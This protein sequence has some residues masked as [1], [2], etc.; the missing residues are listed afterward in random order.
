MSDPAPFALSTVVHLVRPWGEPVTDL[1]ELRAALA[2]A[3]AEV[4]FQHTV[5]V[6][7]RNPAA[8]E[9][10]ADDLS[11]WVAVAAQ[12][13]ETAERLSFAV[14]NRNASPAQVREALVE[15]LDAMPAARRAER[16]AP[17][18][19]ALQLLASE[20]LVL[21]SG[22]VR[23]AGELVAALA[24][25]DPGIWFYHVIEAPWFGGGRTAVVNWLAAAG[26][27]R[28]A[29]WLAAAAS[30]T[31]PLERERDR[32]LRRWRRSRLARSVAAASGAPEHERRDAGR[33]AVARL[34]RRVTRPEETA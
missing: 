29:E 23:D 26:E 8:A 25:D 19:G 14:Q 3:P 21:E 18:E 9:L 32:L 31:L 30:A 15:V 7:L 27:S 12:D 10:P 6:Q 5:Q 33:A 2:D 11:T 22:A 28:L 4:L 13:L 1:D 24:G 17:P 34:V 20:S 16:R